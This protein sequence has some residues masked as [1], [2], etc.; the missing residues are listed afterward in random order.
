MPDIDLS[1]LTPRDQ[2]I[3]DSVVVMKEGS[4]DTM[5]LVPRNRFQSSQ[6]ITAVPSADQADWAP[7]GFNAATGTIKMQ[8]TTNVFLTGLAAGATDQEVTLINDSAF[9]VCFEAESAASLAANRFCKC[10]MTRWVLPH[11]TITYRYSAT[12][13][14]WV[15]VRQTIE[16]GPVNGKMQDLRPNTTTS[17]TTLGWPSSANT[18]TLSTVAPTGTPTNDFLEYGHTQVTNAT[19]N[20]TSSVRSNVQGWMRGATANRQG[21]FHAG[22]VRFTALGNVTGAV[23]AGMLASTGA[24]TTLNSAQT[25]C[26]FLGAETSQTTLRIIHNDA[27]GAAVQIDLGANFPVPNATAAYEYCF[28]APPATASVQY[29][30]RRLDTRFVAQGSLAA[31]LPVNTTALGQRLEIMV[32]ATAVANTAQMAYLLT[33]GL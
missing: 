4:P 9:V 14:Q 3:A 2:D 1:T 31:D 5:G 7:A 18:A 33:Q 29:M 11:S 19:A 25:N 27:A 30:V 10:R 32:G 17:I 15:F 13:T 24:S 6:I 26:L 28:Y 20:G 12:R 16:I 21:F 23:R 8:P 22:M